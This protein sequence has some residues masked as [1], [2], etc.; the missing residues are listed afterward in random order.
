[1]ALNNFIYIH[2]C[3]YTALWSLYLC[4]GGKLAKSSRRFANFSCWL[5]KSSK[6]VR[7]NNFV[8][9]NID[10]SVLNIDGLVPDVDFSIVTSTLK[11][12][13][14]KSIKKKGSCYVIIKI[15]CWPKIRGMST[16]SLNFS[17][18]G[19]LHIFIIVSHS[20]FLV[21]NKYLKFY[22]YPLILFCAR[23]WQFYVFTNKNQCDY[24]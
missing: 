12:K 8:L 18:D 20:I 2:L 11:W 24:M 13:L 19:A 14:I 1:M 3:I 16:F 9:F 6:F 4:F 17:M 10:G 7:Y 5:Y 15:W 21:S 22:M 23:K